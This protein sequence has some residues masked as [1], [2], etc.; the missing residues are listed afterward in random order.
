MV[1]SLQSRQQ[2]VDKPHEDEQAG[3]Q[4]G[5]PDTTSEFSEVTAVPP[6][7][8]HADADGSADAVHAD[9]ERQ[10]A[11]FYDEC[12][13]LRGTWGGVAAGVIRSTYRK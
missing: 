9:A 10:R 1:V 7:H 4:V 12:L 3:G 2:Y 11:G 5:R 6:E 13:A 8:Q